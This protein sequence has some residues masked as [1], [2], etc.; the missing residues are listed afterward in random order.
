M[1]SHSVF[2]PV[3][4]I[5][6]Y[7][8]NAFGIHVPAYLPVDPCIF[9]AGASGWTASSPGRRSACHWQDKVFPLV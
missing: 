4:A 2:F 3:S 1:Y 9:P 8:L 6:A 7:G 5:V